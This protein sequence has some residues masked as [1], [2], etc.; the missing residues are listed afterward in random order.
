MLVARCAADASIADD[1]GLTMHQRYW[2]GVLMFLGLLSAE[3][4]DTPTYNDVYADLR[5]VDKTIR[6]FRP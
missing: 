6:H 2:L 5:D 1:E 4:R 3:C